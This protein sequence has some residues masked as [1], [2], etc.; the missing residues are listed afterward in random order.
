MRSNKESLMDTKNKIVISI[1]VVCMILAVVVVA[2]VTIWAS[3]NQT[4]TSSIRVK[5]TAMEVR[6]TASAQWTVGNNDSWHDMDTNGSASGG[7]KTLTFGETE[8]PNASL[9]PTVDVIDITSGNPFV[10]FKYSFTN[11]GNNDYYVDLSYTDDSSPDENVVVTV[12][13]TVD[14]LSSNYTNSITTDYDDLISTVVEAGG[15]KSIYILVK[16]VDDSSNAS[17]SGTFNCNLDGKN[18]GGM[19]DYTKTDSAVTINGLKEGVKANTLRIP[20]SID[21]V[22]V[23]EITANAF[24]NQTSLTKVIIPDS[25][26]TIGSC[27][28]QG[29]SG[30]QYIELPFVGGKKDIDV[31]T[32]E[33][34][35]IVIEGNSLDTQNLELAAALLLTQPQYSIV[36]FS[37]IF[38]TVTVEQVGEYLNNLTYPYS[39]PSGLTVNVRGGDIY[40]GSFA[41]QLPQNSTVILSEGVTDIADYSFAINFGLKSVTIPSTVANIGNY[42]F[43]M[44]ITLSDVT[45]KNGPKSIGDNAF[46]QC[47]ITS[48][49]IPGS[50]VTIGEQA[51]AECPLT[52]VTIEY[53]VTS[54]GESAFSGCSGLTNLTIPDSVTSIDQY[55]FSNCSSLTNITIPSSVEYISNNAFQ[56]CSSLNNVTIES[57]V[58]SIG[59]SAFY[60]C[61]NLNDVTIESAYIYELAVGTDYYD[62]AGGL[63]GNIIKG[64][65]VTVPTSI[66]EGHTNTYLTDPANYTSK[67]VGTNTVFTKV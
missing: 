42:A 49:T 30:L 39:I 36:T 14:D 34:G 10:V 51:F 65:T 64:G 35:N 22:P 11:I 43:G 38:D 21:G 67:K 57:G 4:I 31:I 47:N 59:S 23:T 9:S 61:S 53:G 25:V 63:L 66:V 5:Y 2:V 3:T 48:I 26:E 28:F 55:A 7:N 13:D 56:G 29:C 12:L 33:D 1:S 37:Y 17:Y 32:D 44:C 40:F 27:A 58:Q 52:D 6:G 20:E 46:T 41:M 50:V 60:N 19:L 24:E 54:I 16:L 18:Y 8:L 15:S 45:I 62:N